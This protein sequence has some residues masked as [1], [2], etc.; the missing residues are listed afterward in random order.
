MH[1][2]IVQTRT[3]ESLKEKNRISIFLFFFQINE[4]PVVAYYAIL[5]SE[6]AN[7]GAAH[8]AMTF[9]K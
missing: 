7:V 9:Q 6:A 5:I 4:A 8:N 1:T 2:T 3:A